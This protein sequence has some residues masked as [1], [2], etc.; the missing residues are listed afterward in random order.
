MYTYVQEE[1]NKQTYMQLCKST[2]TRESGNNYKL[3][4]C[5]KLVIHKSLRLEFHLTAT[6]L[7]AAALHVCL[8]SSIR[9]Y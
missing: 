6:I 3:T 8:A 9:P 7:I 5:T 2:I 4:H 1:Q